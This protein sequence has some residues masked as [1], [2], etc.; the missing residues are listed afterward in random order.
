MERKHCISLLKA[1]SRV[2]RLFTYLWMS[3]KRG[4]LLAGPKWCCPAENR[5]VAPPNVKQELTYNPGP[6]GA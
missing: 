6:A 1:S 2:S 3:D 4:M 5:L